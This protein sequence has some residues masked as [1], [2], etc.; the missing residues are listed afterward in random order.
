MNKKMNKK[1]V[2]L[3][4]TIG[5]Y[6]AVMVSTSLYVPVKASIRVEEEDTY[7]EYGYYPVWK[8]RE[9]KVEN[10]A[11]EVSINITAWVIQ[12][13]FITLVFIFLLLRVVR[14]PYFNQ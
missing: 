10:P 6:I 8:I 13:V 14:G 11:L 9:A 2:A 7:V 5:T 1:K 3:I 4:I 12:Y